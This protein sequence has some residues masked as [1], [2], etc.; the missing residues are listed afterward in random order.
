M[1]RIVTGLF[2]R[3]REVDLVVEHLV[4][5]FDIPRQRVLVHV[6]GK[7][8]TEAVSPQEHDSSEG[9]ELPEEVVRGYADGLHRGGIML[10]AWVDDA[11][12]QRA[13]DACQEYGAESIAAH[14]SPDDTGH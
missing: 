11:H 4:Q 10:A 3:R 8:G 7:D 2:D 14:D 1:T 6:L 5:E 13:L 12:V 9:P